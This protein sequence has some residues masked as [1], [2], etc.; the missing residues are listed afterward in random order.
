MFEARGQDNIASTSIQNLQ[1]H[2]NFQVEEWE[3]KTKFKLCKKRN[4]S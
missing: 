1:H 3:R 2:R 4:L